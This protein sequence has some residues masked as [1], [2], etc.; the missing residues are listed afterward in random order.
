MKAPHLAVFVVCV[1]GGCYGP[2]AVNEIC[3]NL[4]T[5]VHSLDIEPFGPVDPDLLLAGCAREG[6]PQMAIRFYLRHGIEE[7]SEWCREM[8]PSL[9]DREDILNRICDYIYG[10]C[11]RIMA[12]SEKSVVELSQGGPEVD[13]AMCLFGEGAVG[14]LIGHPKYDPDSKDWERAFLLTY[15]VFV[16]NELSPEKERFRYF[17]VFEPNPTYRDVLSKFGL[18]QWMVVIDA[19]CECELWYRTSADQE[20]CYADE[21]WNV[22]F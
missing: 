12:K 10:Y 21:L 16:V 20:G 17:L 22:R 11:F 19:S 7:L 9:S 14:E 2:E 6:R 15:G 8:Y 4:K 1:S 13:G 3:C 18:D 5:T